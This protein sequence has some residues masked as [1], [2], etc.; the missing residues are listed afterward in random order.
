MKTLERRSKILERIFGPDWKYVVIEIIY[1]ALYMPVRLHCWS[2]VRV[3]VK[4]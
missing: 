2:Y 3:A 1:S 4:P